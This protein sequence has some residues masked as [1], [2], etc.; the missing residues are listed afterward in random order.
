MQ[1]SRT[2]PVWAELLQLVPVIVLACSFLVTG[3]VDLERAGPLFLVAA[4][5]TVPIT[6]LLS[7]RGYVL[8]P[9]LLG[10]ALWLWLGALAFHLP[11]PWLADWI[12]HTR[13]VG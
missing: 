7:A 11:M 8:N 3:Q 2:A 13:G 9:I 12:A 5:L 1:A 4:G 10:V 6:A